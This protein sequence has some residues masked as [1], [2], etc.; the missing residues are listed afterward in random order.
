[1]EP[2]FWEI[3]Y[4]WGSSFIGICLKFN[5]NFSNARRKIQKFFFVFDIIACHRLS[6]CYTVLGF[7]VSLTETSSNATTSTVIN[8]YCKGAALQIAK[9]CLPICR[10]VCLMVLWKRVFWT[11]L[12]PYFSQPVFPETHQL[13]GSPFLAHV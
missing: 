11:F 7:C 5:I 2:F 6:M 10:V 1:M 3:H 13:W 4:L 8:N 9:F 12:K